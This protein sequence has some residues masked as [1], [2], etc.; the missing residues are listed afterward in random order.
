MIFRNKEGALI[1]TQPAPT[2][3]NIYSSQEDRVKAVEDAIVSLAEYTSEDGISI[4][5]PEL[6]I[7]INAIRQEMGMS[8]EDP[9]IHW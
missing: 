3:R 5:M 2:P 9:N 8:P 7:I 4:N 1:N 6:G